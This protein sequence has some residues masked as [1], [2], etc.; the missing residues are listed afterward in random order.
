MSKNVAGLYTD[1]TPICE[2][3]KRTAH[4]CEQNLIS[5]NFVKTI[6]G[7]SNQNRD[8]LDQSFMYTQ[9]LKEILFTIHFEPAHF[10]E[11]LTYSREQLAGNNAELKNVDMIQKEYH[12]HQPIW[13]YTYNC[14]LYC[15]LDRALRLME[16]DHIIKNKSIKMIV[17]GRHI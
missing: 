11:F 3:V 12:H 10:Y 7:T 15:M 13:W 8:T 2:A 14:F 1:I 9:V 6:D 17:Y 5:V 4:D 16:V